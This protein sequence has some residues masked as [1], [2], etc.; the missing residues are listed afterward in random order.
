MK[1]IEEEQSSFSVYNEQL[2]GS[3]SEPLQTFG[4]VFLPIKAHFKQI[5]E[6]ALSDNFDV[7]AYAKKVEQIQN[8]PFLTKEF[9]SCFNRLAIQSLLKSFIQ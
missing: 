9:R 4:A 7:A 3:D 2:T 5:C 8:L 1:R 6:E